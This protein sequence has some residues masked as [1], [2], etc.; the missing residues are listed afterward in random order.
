MENKRNEATPNRPEGDRVLD[1]PFVFADLLE[2]AKQLKEEE[3]WSKN[4]RNGITVYKSDKLTIVLSCLH[5]E[6]VLKHKAIEGT[7][8]IQ[9]LDGKISVSTQEGDVTMK[10]HQ[11]MAFH[12]C[13]D[14]SI[15]ALDDST[16]LLNIY[17]P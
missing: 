6:A 17:K 2:Y 15:T 10:E 9:V 4:D 11:I 13:V 12:E 16:L 5:E 8:T 3:A 7:F 1:A 14:Q